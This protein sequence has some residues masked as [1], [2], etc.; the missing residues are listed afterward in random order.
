MLM[1]TLCHIS[2]INVDLQ[3]NINTVVR[4]VLMLN[5]VRNGVNP[6][7]V[8][9]VMDVDTVTHAPSNS[10]ILKYISLLSAM[11]CNRPATAPEDCSVPSPMLNVNIIFY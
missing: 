6:V 3:G 2:R 11:M 10:F 9:Q 7:I 1:I 8:R 4:H 5:T